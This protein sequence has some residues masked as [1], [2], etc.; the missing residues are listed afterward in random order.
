MSKFRLFIQLVFSFKWYV[1]NSHP[2]SH[3]RRKKRNRKE[4]ISLK[5]ADALF[6]KSYPDCELLIIMWIVCYFQDQY[7]QQK[8]DHEIKMRDGTAKLLAASK[9]PHQLLEAAKNLL[10]SNTRMIAYMSEL[11]KRKTDEVLKRRDSQDENQIPCKAQI[12]LSG[13][14]FTKR[15]YSKMMYPQKESYNI[16]PNLS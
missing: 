8:I 2:K 4:S 13:W 3:S 15:G 1:G 6:H 12:C 10:T 7:L 11:Q 16:G 14:Y 9:R 5:W